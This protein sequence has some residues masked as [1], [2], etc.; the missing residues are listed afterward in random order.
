MATILLIEDCEPSRRAVKRLL[1]SEGHHV[2]AAENGWQ[3][4]GVMETVDVDLVVLDVHLPGLDGAQV[5]GDKAWERRW[6]HVP[7]IVLSGAGPDG[8]LIRRHN[9]IRHWM[10]KGEMTPDELVDAVRQSL[11]GVN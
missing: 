8:R 11:V 3:G 4:L 6:S 5:L 1:E 9:R 2:F 7:V 10:E